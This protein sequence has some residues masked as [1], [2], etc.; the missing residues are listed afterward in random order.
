MIFR[1]ARTARFFFDPDA[2]AA[3]AA[4]ARQAYLAAEPFPHALFDDLLPAWVVRRLA[5]EFPPPESFERQEI[6]DQPQ[7]RGKL[8]SR[9]ERGFGGFTRQVLDHLNGDPFVAFLERLTGIEGLVADPDIAHSLRHYERGGTL[10]VHA[11][12]NVHPRL[13]LDR[14]LNVLIYLTPG[15]RPEW[16]GELELWD[17]G[18]TRS[19]RRIEPRFGRV[20]VFTVSDRNPHGFP[21]P[22]A[23][24]P[25]V[26]RRSVNLY[27]YTNGRPAEEVAPPHPT[28]W[29]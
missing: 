7:R 3:R 14:R 17:A 19:V 23:C 25:G 13:K 6:P 20:V 11:D 16:H 29:R 27:Y 22:L 21:Q 4:A 2:L 18:A 28:L 8:Q 10:G 26:T 24:P 9:D 15:W 12:F 5:D 1:R